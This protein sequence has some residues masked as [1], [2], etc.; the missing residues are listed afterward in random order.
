LRFDFILDGDCAW[1]SQFEK[2]T[3]AL[4]AWL[5]RGGPLLV[6]ASINNALAAT[7]DQ[8]AGPATRASSGGGKLLIA[9]RDICL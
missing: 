3:Y 8:D 2:I 7:T 1:S 5:A 9:A 4:P 6:I